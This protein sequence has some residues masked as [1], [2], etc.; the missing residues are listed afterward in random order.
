MGQHDMTRDTIGRELNDWPGAFDTSNSCNQWLFNGD[1]FKRLWTF[2]FRKDAMQH[3]FNYISGNFEEVQVPH[4]FN[5]K[6]IS[7]LVLPILGW[8]DNH[9]NINYKTTFETSNDVEIYRPLILWFMMSR[10]YALAAFLQ[11]KKKQKTKSK[12]YKS[13]ITNKHTKTYKHS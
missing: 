10:S 8:N 3:S 12:N 9:I 6:D 11:A 7:S 13:T 5:H 1:A 4:C 2:C